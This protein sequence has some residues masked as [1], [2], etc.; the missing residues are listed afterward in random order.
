MGTFQALG[1]LEATPSPGVHLHPHS[2]ENPSPFNP[3]APGLR[4]SGTGPGPSAHVSG[5]QE[6]VPSTKL[7]AN[8]A[9]SQGRIIAAAPLVHRTLT[10]SQSRHRTDPLPSRILGSPFRAG[11][12][13]PFVGAGSVQQTC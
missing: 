10:Q 7:V 8:G 11:P 3:E 12:P 2:D 9:L 1:M 6:S 13:V 5:C 4:I